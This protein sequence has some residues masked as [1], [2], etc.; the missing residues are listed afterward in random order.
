MLALNPQN[1]YSWFPLLLPLQLFVIISTLLLALFVLFVF[2]YSFDIRVLTR[3]LVFFFD[4]HW[5]RC[6]LT[7]H[8][9]I[10]TIKFK[11]NRHEILRTHLLNNNNCWA[12]ASLSA[13]CEWS[14][15]CGVSFHTILL[16]GRFSMCEQ[17]W[18]APQNGHMD[19]RYE[20]KTASKNSSN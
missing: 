3:Y 13:N 20:K 16:A 2:T 6:A 11:S 10:F 8:R 15:V 19:L 17:R 18:R 14:L 12:C 1:R 7:D 4:V 9:D 5:T